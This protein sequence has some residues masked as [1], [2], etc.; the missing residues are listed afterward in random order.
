M[1]VLIICATTDIRSF[2]FSLLI[3]LPSNSLKILLCF[4]FR[5]L[6]SKKLARHSQPHLL[7]ISGI[8]SGMTAVTKYT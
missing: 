1:A 6:K 4:G 3:V 5:C 2:E 8:V 7:K